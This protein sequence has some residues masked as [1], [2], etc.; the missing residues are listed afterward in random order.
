VG[1]YTESLS[2]LSAELIATDFSDEMVKAAKDR[3]AGIPKIAVEKADCLNLHYPDNE[4]DSVFMANLLHVIPYPEKVIAQTCRVLKNGGK[5]V[6]TSYT[7]EGMTFLNKIRMA[8][9]YSRT[10][11]RPPTGGSPITI[12]RAL[13]ILGNHGFAD[14]E[15]QLIGSGSK[16]I[17]ATASINN[18]KYNHTY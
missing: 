17:F 16:A 5:I 11:G 3:F 6:I 15:A 1:T 7:P 2:E 10:W 12:K 14:I 18:K 8:Y 4:F 9:R 13:D